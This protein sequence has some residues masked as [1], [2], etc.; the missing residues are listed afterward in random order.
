MAKV[1]KNKAKQFS[2]WIL[3]IDETVK[4]RDETKFLMAKVK[5]LGGLVIPAEKITVFD[6][7]SLVVSS[8]DDLSITVYPSVRTMVEAMDFFKKTY[9]QHFE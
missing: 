6:D 2:E 3:A 8:E 9:P 7:G 5:S 1:K 4:P